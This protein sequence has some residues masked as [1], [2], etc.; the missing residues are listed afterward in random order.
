M[1]IGD[2]AHIIE[3]TI[4]AIGLVLAVVV[5]V[6]KDRSQTINRLAKQI[7]AYYA[8]EQEAIAIIQGKK[9]L[10]ANTN[11]QSVR[12]I[13]MTLRERAEVACG[14]Y[15]NMTEKEALKYTYTR[16]KCLCECILDCIKRIKKCI[17]R[18]KN[19]NNNT[20]THQS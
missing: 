13:K 18:I 17:Q 7:I 16:R 8:E 1:S 3:A 15:P 6:R 9:P 12:T 2:I 14:I 20:K 19:K 5:F 4:A 10:P 11:I